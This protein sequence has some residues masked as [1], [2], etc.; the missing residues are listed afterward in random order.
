[1]D[2][3]RVAGKGK[4][5]KGKVREGFGKA[6][7]NDRQIAKGKAEQ[8]GGKVQGKYGKAKDKVRN[9]I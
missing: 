9:I 2:K 8:V 5:V 1:M 3:D 6:T 7:G 4:E